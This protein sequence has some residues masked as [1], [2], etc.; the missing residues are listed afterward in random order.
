MNLMQ[1]CVAASALLAA[2]QQDAQEAGSRFPDDRPW[3]ALPGSISAEAIRDDELRLLGERPIDKS[4]DHDVMRFVVDMSFETALAITVRKLKWL[5]RT[6]DGLQWTEDYDLTVS[7]M[8][9]P[10]TVHKIP[11]GNHFTST[12]ERYF[13]RISSDEFKKA[14]DALFDS[15]FFADP[16]FVPLKRMCA[17]GTGYFIEAK[18]GQHYNWIGRYYCYGRFQEDFS[19]AQILL[20]LAREKLPMLETKFDAVEKNIKSFE[21]R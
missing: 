6:E 19:D 16:V 18:L 20:R 8:D 5:D 7:F 13:V 12:S 11:E 15:G 2:N 10:E 14:A 1:I 21:K 3:E 4:A 17:D 9:Y